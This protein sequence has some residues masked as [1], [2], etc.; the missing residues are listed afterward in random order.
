MI[1]GGDGGV[2]REVVKHESVERVDLVDID[3]A[4]PR[5]S[6]KYLPKMSVGFQ[7]PKVHLHIMDGL[8]FLQDKVDTYDVIITDSSDPDGSPKLDRTSFEV[9]AYTKQLLDRPR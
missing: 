7:H 9:H 1:G 4:V 5:V 8:A 3:E 2:L 6:Q